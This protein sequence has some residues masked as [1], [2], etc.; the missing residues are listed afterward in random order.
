VSSVEA[1]I[2]YMPRVQ[3]ESMRHDELVTLEKLE[4]LRM[5]SAQQLS[6]FVALGAGVLSFVSPCVLPLR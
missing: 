3:N 4:V 6:V 2:E 5:K 1:L